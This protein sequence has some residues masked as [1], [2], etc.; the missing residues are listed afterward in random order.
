[1]A[2][3]D[4]AGDDRRQEIARSLTAVRAR[5]EGACR[6][7]GRSPSEVTLVVVTK[8]HPVADI[9]RLAALGVRDVGE[10][11]DQEAAPKAADL[12]GHGLVW[13]F[14]GQLQRNKVRSALRYVDVFH[15]IDRDSLIASVSRAADELGRQVDVLLQVDLDPDGA[16]ATGRGGARPVDLARLAD[17]VA[18]SPGLALRGLMAVAPRPPI[19][20]PG[21]T[22]APGPTS[23]R[24]SFERL[25]ALSDTLRSGHPQARWVSA[26]M[27]ADLE[28]AVA[29]GA[30]HLRVG[31]AVLGS[32]ASL[33]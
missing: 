9:Q 27:S 17:R 28:D 30:T 21:A 12:V 29:C 25:A 2:G 8:T 33:G 6:S 13:H 32:R 24:S 11:R 3:E 4:V 14:V 7:A 1:V 23:A 18:D 16:A 5:V 31:S 15:T 22:G 19:S 10:N 20:G 26:G